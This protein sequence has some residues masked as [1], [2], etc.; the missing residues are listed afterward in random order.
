[1]DHADPSLERG[2]QLLHHPL[3][4]AD[5]VPGKD[6]GVKTVTASTRMGQGKGILPPSP[7]TPPPNPKPNPGRVHRK[8]DIPWRCGKKRVVLSCGLFFLLLATPGPLRAQIFHVQGGSSSLIDAH[9]GSVE[10]QAPNYS[11]AVGIGTINGEFSFGAVLRTEFHGYRLTAGD[12]IIPFTLPTDVFD[13]N[14]FFFGRGAGVAR[15]KGRFEFAA[16]VGATSSLFGAP[17][18][19]AAKAHKPFGLIFTQYRKSEHLRF[20]TRTIVSDKQTFIGGV[21]WSARKWLTASFSGG[22]GSNAPYAAGAL[23]IE[24]E[25]VTFKAA[26]IS[27]SKDFRRV[28]VQVPLV[29]EVDKENLLLTLRPIRNF[30]VTL[31][32]QN[33]LSPLLSKQPSVHGTVQEISANANLF[34]IRLSGGVYESRVSGTNNLGYS[35]SAGRGLGRKVD[36]GVDFYRTKPERGFTSTSLN[37]RVR[38]NLTQKFSLTEYVSRSNGQTSFNFGGE[39]NSDRIS[40]SVSHETAYVPFRPSAAGG[41]FVHFYNVGLR[42]RLFGNVQVTGQTN[43]APD[44]KVKYTAGASDHLYRYAGLESGGK[45]PS[46]KIGK[47]VVKGIVQIEPGAPVAG[48]ALQVDG[49][50]AFTD[51]NGEFLVRFDKKQKVN[52]VVLL[53]EFLVGTPYRVVEAPASVE[54]ALEDKAVAITVVLKRV[55]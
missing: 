42:F 20:V 44:G 15:K 34:K 28:N 55:H 38:E 16:F 46:L 50:V 6:R 22:A 40:L 4:G 24:R 17:F 30:S 27:P 14:H 45:S 49:R 43:V 41:P 39:Y 32:R 51:S 2:A 18:F 53:D 48:A 26:Y 25:K 9:G 23:V 8:L 19:Q 33:L 37:T 10:F 31:S 12:D 29:S 47:Y 3:A 52:F 54:T 13:N 1:M 11:G 7:A 21:E 35:F 36:V 5:A